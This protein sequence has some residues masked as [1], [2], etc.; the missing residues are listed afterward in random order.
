MRSEPRITV[1]CD[2]C[3]C[4]LEMGLTACAGSFY[5]ERNIETELKANGWTVDGDDLC[6]T[7]QLPPEE[8]SC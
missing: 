5:D 7:C 1:T 4:H 8:G 6:K 2:N 3:G